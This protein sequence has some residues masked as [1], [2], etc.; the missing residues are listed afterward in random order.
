MFPHRVHLCL[1]FL[2]SL[3]NLRCALPSLFVR[4]AVWVFHPFPLV[5]TLRSDQQHETHKY[6]QGQ[7]LKIKKEQLGSKIAFIILYLS[8]P[9]ETW[10]TTEWDRWF[11]SYSLPLFTRTLIQLF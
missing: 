5:M 8:V 3:M 9:A 7:S 6:L 11:V 2:S 10:P 4:S 1:V